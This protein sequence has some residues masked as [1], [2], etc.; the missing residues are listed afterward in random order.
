MTVFMS[1]TASVGI[2]PPEIL[3]VS[4]P[5]IKA[6]SPTIMTNARGGDAD[7]ND[8]TLEQTGPYSSLSLRHY[9]P[10]VTY[11]GVAARGRTTL[12]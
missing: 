12:L 9:V 3:M 7:R 5:R 6:Q 8:I 2:N 1:Q 10:C 11:G 4:F